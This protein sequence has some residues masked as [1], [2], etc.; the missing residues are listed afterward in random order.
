MRKNKNNLQLLYVSARNIIESRILLITS[1]SAPVPV[2]ARDATRSFSQH[3]SHRVCSFSCG[4]FCPGRCSSTEQQMGGNTFAI[5]K[6][7]RKYRFIAEEPGC[8][9]EQSF[10]TSVTSQL[11]SRF[12]SFMMTQDPCNRGGALCGIK[13]SA[14]VLQMFDN[15]ND[16]AACKADDL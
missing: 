2:R 11:A 8:V 6:M 15:I 16:M 5:F 4:C 13:D 14:T 3:L 12:D 1:S 9:A 7:R 10:A